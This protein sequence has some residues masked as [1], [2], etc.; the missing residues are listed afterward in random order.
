MVDVE[1]PLFMHDRQNV[2]EIFLLDLKVLQ[3][4]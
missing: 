3:S 4:K 1:L 2:F